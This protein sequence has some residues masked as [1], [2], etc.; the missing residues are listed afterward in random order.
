MPLTF[1]LLF[2]G[3]RSIWIA[4]LLALVV[5]LTMVPASRA[6]RAAL[7]DGP[8]AATP[9]SLAQMRI[10]RVV[11]HFAPEQAARLLSRASGGDISPELAGMFLRDMARGRGE[12]NPEVETTKSTR[13]VGGAKFVTVD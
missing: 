4:I 12:A 3:A 1:R 6:E 7:G 2:H 10:A 9:L 13:S 11:V 8:L 5:W